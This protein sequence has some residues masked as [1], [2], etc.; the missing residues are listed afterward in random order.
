MVVMHDLS[1]SCHTP[2]IPDSQLHYNRASLNSPIVWQLSLTKNG[3][4]ESKV[5]R[6]V[7]L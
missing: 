4:L 2:K 6:L 5:E 7:S 1:N 3:Y